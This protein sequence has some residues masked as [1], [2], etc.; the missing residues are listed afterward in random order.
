MSAIEFLHITLSKAVPAMHAKRVVVLCEAV[1]S[2]LVGARVCITELGRHLVS[3]AHIKHN[4]KRMDRLIGNA[5][6]ASERESV[7]GVIASLLLKNIARP[8][9]LI[10]WSE[11]CP[12]QAQHVL[13]A[14]LPVGGRALTL[15]EQVYPRRQLGNRQVQINFLNKLGEF[16]SENQKPIIVADAGFRVPFYQVVD[17]KGWHWV[18]RIRNRD[19]ISFAGENCFFSAISLYAKAKYKALYLGGIHWTQSKMLNALLVLVKPKKKCRVRKTKM[20]IKSQ[21]AQSK[22]QSRREAEPL[23]LVY[24]CSLKSLSADQVVSI[25]KTRMQIEEN[26]RDTKSENFGVGICKM[27]RINIQRR[28]VLLMIAALAQFVLWMTGQEIKGSHLEKQ[29]RVNS[30]S[31]KTSYS[32]VFLA[33]QFYKLGIIVFDFMSLKKCFHTLGLVK[34]YQDSVF[35]A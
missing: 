9:I 23:L 28:G 13:R 14:S 3:G 24:S 4:I 8:I 31:K 16:L 35:E 1:K 33:R 12:D 7:Y 29:F 11:L 17:Q 25:Y 15:F 10:D 18:G 27:N 6:M 2:T 20:N 26:F 19:Y 21:S 34:T 5:H 30:R 32:V 22:K